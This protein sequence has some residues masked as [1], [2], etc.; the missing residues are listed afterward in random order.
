MRSISIL[1]LLAACDGSEPVVPTA[2]DAAPV[3]V[4]A[5]APEPIAAASTPVVPR[6]EATPERL[7]PPVVAR[8]GHSLA[9]VRVRRR[10]GPKQGVG[11]GV[12]H[13]VRA[14]E[15][16][17]ESQSAGPALPQHFV[18]VVSCAGGGI[19]KDARLA[20]DVVSKRDP[21]QPLPSDNRKIPE[22]L[23]RRYGRIERL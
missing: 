9:I 22:H 19:E 13:F 6:V 10:F 18:L 17:L 8:P 23:E 21:R 3:E 14:L 11:C 1:L 7:D 5:A 15:V 2:I 20:I 4:A 16:E 12:I